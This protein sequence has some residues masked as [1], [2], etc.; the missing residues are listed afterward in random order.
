MSS[1]LLKWLLLTC[2]IWDGGLMSKCLTLCIRSAQ[3]PLPNLHLIHPAANLPLAVCPESVLM[4]SFK[5]HR[6]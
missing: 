6:E 4:Y 5:I 2:E 1:S 3:E